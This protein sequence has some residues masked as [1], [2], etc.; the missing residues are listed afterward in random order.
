MEVHPPHLPLPLQ[1]RFSPYRSLQETFAYKL[2]FCA[3]TC[4]SIRMFLFLFFHK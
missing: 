3:F 2:Y 1:P 4:P